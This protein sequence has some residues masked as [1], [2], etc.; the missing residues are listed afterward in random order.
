MGKQRKS[1]RVNLNVSKSF[2]KNSYAI[3]PFS[4]PQPN[5]APKNIFTM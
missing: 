4:L 2:C 3:Q 5:M 1:D